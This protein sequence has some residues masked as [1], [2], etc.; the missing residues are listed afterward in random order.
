MAIECSQFLRKIR[1]LRL[2]HAGTRHLEN[3]SI[4]DTEFQQLPWT[5]PN[6]Q[7]LYCKQKTVPL[8]IPIPPVKCVSPPSAAACCKLFSLFSHFPPR[9]VSPEAG[10]PH[11]TSYIL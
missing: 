4:E 6:S 10:D 7:T 2:F 8:F 9:A 5:P 11:L 1:W 3:A